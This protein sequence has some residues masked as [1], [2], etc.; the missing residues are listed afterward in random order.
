MTSLT[1]NISK[2]DFSTN[3][4]RVKNHVKGVAWIG[5]H[6]SIS[7]FE[8]K[9]NTKTRLYTTVLCF[10]EENINFRNSIIDFYDAKVNNLDEPKILV[11][12]EFSNVIP[13]II[14]KYNG[15]NTLSSFIFDSKN[16]NFN[17]IGP[18]G[19]GLEIKESSN[20]TFVIF[21]GG[22][23]VLP[24]V[25][26]FDYLLK[27][28]IYMILAKKYKQSEADKTNPFLENYQGTF[29]EN[30]KVRLFWAVNDEYEFNYLSFLKKLFEINEKYGL[31]IFDLTVRIKSKIEGVK[32]TQEFFDEGFLKRNL[33][34]NEIARIFVC[35]NPNMNYSIPEGCKKIGIRK[36]LIQMI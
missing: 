14:K 20:G 36:E 8:S 3:Q 2:F 26:L 5:R 13:L 18:F 29:G 25:D 6:F 33:D 21:A 7:R 32:T 27:K 23:G 34:V 10:T 17:I 4:L 16:Q 11:P 24:F 15:Q 1:S 31:N 28:S 30:F 35:G 22:T 19:T 12:Q 9:E